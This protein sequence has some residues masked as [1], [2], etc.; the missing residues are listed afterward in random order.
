MVRVPVARVGDGFVELLFEWEAPPGADLCELRLSGTP[1]V[2]P[3]D[4]LHVGLHW[5]DGTAVVGRGTQ[6]GVCTNIS[7]GHL[8]RDRAFFGIEVSCH[9]G[10]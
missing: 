2:D 7:F 1:D 8:Q 5:S 6:D 4:L 3:A 9:R 10:H